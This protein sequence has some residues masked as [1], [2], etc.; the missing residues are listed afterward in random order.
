MSGESREEF[1]RDRMGE[2]GDKLA[3]D[4]PA[5]DERPVPQWVR[6]IPVR[7]PKPFL[8]R[9]AFCFLGVGVGI[10][11]ALD[12]RSLLAEGRPFDPIVLW[13]GAWPQ[14]AGWPGS[15]YSVVFH[16]DD[17]WAPECGPGRGVIGELD[18]TRASVLSSRGVELRRSEIPP[19][20]SKVRL[21]YHGANGGG[22]V[23]GGLMQ[24]Y[25]FDEA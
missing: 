2:T 25:Y 4:K 10:V 17:Y 16:G 20:T 8:S 3:R 11:G 23:G 19:G 1:E 7:E 13:L 6:D 12:P 5:R 15:R 24:A 9:R 18:V 21:V 14:E 22:D